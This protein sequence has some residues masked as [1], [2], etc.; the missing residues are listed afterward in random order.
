MRMN[1]NDQKI[2]EK[3]ASD[4]FFTEYQKLQHLYSWIR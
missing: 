1:N 4:N 2:K 3:S